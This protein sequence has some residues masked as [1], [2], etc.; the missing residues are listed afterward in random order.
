MATIFGSKAVYGIL[1]FESTDDAYL[2]AHIHTISSRIPGYVK[3]VAVLEN[4]KVKKGDVLVKLDETD[5]EPA[6]S[7]YQYC[8]ARRR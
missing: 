2:Q 6:V 8:R 3:T 5:V 1:W 4:Q 7:V